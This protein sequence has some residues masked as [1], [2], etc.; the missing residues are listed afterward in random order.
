MQSVLGNERLAR[1]SQ[2]LQGDEAV[3]PIQFYRKAKTYQSLH[4]IWRAQDLG[5]PPLIAVLETNE[6]NRSLR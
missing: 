5:Q 3:Q 1:H 2:L 6:L 4:L